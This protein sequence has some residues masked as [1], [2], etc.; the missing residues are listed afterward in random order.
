MSSYKYAQDSLFDHHS[1]QLLLPGQ[2][3]RSYSHQRPALL[4]VASH[5]VW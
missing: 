5:D 1:R 2:Q 3:G 4:G